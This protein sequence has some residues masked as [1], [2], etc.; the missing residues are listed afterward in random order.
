MHLEWVTFI[1][2]VLYLIF[3]IA[4]GFYFKSSAG[5]SRK[6]FFLAG[7]NQPWWLAGISIV[8]TTFAADTPLVVS[9]LI[10]AKGMSGNWLWFGVCGAHAGVV[11][12]FSKYWS[13]AGTLT[14]S[15]LISMRYSG[16]FV[17]PL[18]LF[19]AGL[20]GFALNCIIMGWVIRAMVKISSQ[21]FDWQEISPDLYGFVASFWPTGSAL[22]TPNEGITIL[23][24]SYES[25]SMECCT[26]SLSQWDDSR[27][28]ETVDLNLAE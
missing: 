13:R 14:D 18:R 26:T 3:T 16:K 12:L 25:V 2:I 11:V 28:G 21:F 27:G 10:A 19:R 24:G 4:V 17:E 8:A 7:R 15:E 1:P 9:G 6:D 22:G 5:Q 20:S 23:E